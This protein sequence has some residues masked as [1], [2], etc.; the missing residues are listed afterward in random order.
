VLQELRQLRLEVGEKGRR[1]FGEVEVLEVVHQQLRGEQ[2]HDF[3]LQGIED[4]GSAE[5]LPKRVHLAA[6]C[7]VQLRVVVV[8]RLHSGS[9]KSLKFGRR[10]RPRVFRPLAALLDA[11]CERAAGRLRRRYGGGFGGL[12]R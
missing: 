3:E 5:G 1:E 2:R 11:R 8:A 6:D 10:Q 4:G 7:A 12:E 9:A